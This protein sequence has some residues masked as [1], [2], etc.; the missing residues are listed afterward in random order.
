MAI[1]KFVSH[2][3]PGQ[4]NKCYKNPQPSFGNHEH[5]RKKNQLTNKTRKKENKEKKKKKRNKG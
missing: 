1:S 2:H 5:E 4:T 3:I